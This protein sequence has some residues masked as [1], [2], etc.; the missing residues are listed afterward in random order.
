MGSPSAW[1]QAG[2][3]AGV[4][5]RARATPAGRAAVV[6]EATAPYPYA[7]TP[8]MNLTMTVVPILLS[9]EIGSGLSVNNKFTQINN[10]R[11]MYPPRQQSI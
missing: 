2:A 5:R 8:G 7:V 11:T 4:M 10:V 6:P 1:R 9:V 3:Y